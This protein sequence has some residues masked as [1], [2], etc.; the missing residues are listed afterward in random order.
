M[1]GAALGFS[2]PLAHLVTTGLGPFY[3]GLLHFLETPQDVLPVVALSLF[4]GMRG[5]RQGR[6]VL[7]LLTAAWL[8]GGLAGLAVTTPRFGPAA[9]AA[10]LLLCGLLVATDAPLPASATALLAAAIGLAHGLENGGALGAMRA[11]VLALS[12][13]V[14]AIFVV[15]ALAAALVISLRPAW[16]RIAVRVAGSWIAAIG[17]LL[18]GWNLRSSR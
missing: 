18:V 1:R 6:L 8:V 12:G 16:A 13:I 11:G 14:T 15:N 10:S 5:A 2:V 17:L 7:F 3:D 9:A 4:A